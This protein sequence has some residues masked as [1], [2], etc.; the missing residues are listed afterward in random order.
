MN[1][2]DMRKYISG[3]LFFITA[4]CLAAAIAEVYGGTPSAGIGGYYETEFSARRDSSEFEWNLSGFKH[5]F[6]GKF[7]A[8]PAGGV[9]FYSQISART[10]DRFNQKQLFEFER[11]WGKWWFGGGEFLALAREE[12]HWID[13]PLLKILDQYKASYFNNGL[14][15]RLNIFPS[16]KSPLA[17]SLIFTQRIPDASR[18]EW[19]GYYYDEKNSHNLVARMVADFNRAGIG[20]SGVAESLYLGGT[21]IRNYLGED[22]YTSDGRFVAPVKIVNEVYSLDL[23]AGILPESTRATLAGE[24]SFSAKNTAMGAQSFSPSGGNAMTTAAAL[25]IR[26]VNI[27]PF[28]LQGRIY[29]YDD[30]YRSELSRAF[31]R[32]TRDGNDSDKEFSR[33]G[34]YFESSYLWP[35]RMITFTYKKSAYSSRFDYLTNNQDIREDYIVY[36]TT[37]NYQVSYDAIESRIDFTN[38]LKNTIILDVSHNRSGNWPGFLFELSGDTKEVYS[39]VQYRLKDIGSDSGGLGERHILGIETRYNLSEHLQLYARA[40]SVSAVKRDLNWASAFYQLR[41]FVGWDVEGYLEYGDGWHTDSLAY[42]SDI[43]DYSTGRGFADAVRIIFKV[44]F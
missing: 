34:Y 14:G 3:V 5:Y 6:Q 25:E 4:L 13:S 17:A 42:D 12:R 22:K 20:L 9:D 19:Y 43:T 18:Q 26:D 23:K 27:P 24:Y 29:N 33:N 8:N 1:F 2:P 15:G 21:Y 38:G 28:R 16:G 44:N 7:W 32:L 39:R 37:E 41:Y 30:G 35:R 36:Y 10:N 40:V 31:G 11:G